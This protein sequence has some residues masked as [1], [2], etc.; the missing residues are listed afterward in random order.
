ML[1]K[2]ML[3]KLNKVKTRPGANTPGTQTHTLEWLYHH[4]LISMCLN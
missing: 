1:N 3:N 2:Y 4:F